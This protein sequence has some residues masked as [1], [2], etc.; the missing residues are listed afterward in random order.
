MHSQR[1]IEQDGFECIWPG[2]NPTGSDANAVCDYVTFG[3]PRFPNVSWRTPGY[4]RD[5]MH[6][7]QH[8]RERHYAE[9]GR[10]I[11]E[12]VPLIKGRKVVIVC[13]GPSLAVTFAGPPL[14]IGEDVVVLGINHACKALNLQAPN[15][16][17]FISE[18]HARLDWLTTEGTLLAGIPEPTPLVTVP[19]ASAWLCDIWPVE[20][21]FYFN[22]DWSECPNDSRERFPYLMPIHITPTMAVHFAVYCG[23]E[24]IVFLGMDFALDLEGNYY[25][26]MHAS[27]H[28]NADEHAMLHVLPGVRNTGACAS[29]RFLEYHRNLMEGVV[30][31]AERS[32]R[33]P[34]LNA[35][36][37]GIFD[38]RP[39]PLEEALNG[40]HE[41]IVDR[42][43]GEIETPCGDERVTAEGLR[44]KVARILV[45]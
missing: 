24:R 3:A 29:S 27:A 16:Y 34:C 13:P 21:R 1:L 28:P 12:L 30:Y 9:P 23:A 37:G 40:K 42:F 25:W 11:A 7:I 41:P 17:A 44:T 5:F 6:T 38:W 31:W 45:P 36:D 33:I 2:I 10:S 4:N 35:S 22:M 14:P 8:N 32:A 26:D 18:R 43:T 19:E 39:M 15:H 20:N